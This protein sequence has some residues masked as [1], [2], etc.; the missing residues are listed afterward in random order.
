MSGFEVRN[1]AGSVTVNSD[2]KSPLLTNYIASPPFDTTG[3]WDANIPDMGRLKDLAYLKDSIL[4]NGGAYNRNYHKPGQIMWV[5]LNVGGWGLP[6]CDYYIPGS[7]N[8]AFTRMDATVESG[9][10]DVFNSSGQLIWSA[11]SAA[12]VPRIIGF[13]TVPP[14]FD[15]LNNT[16]TVS[17]PGRPFFPTDMF[18]GL[19]S[20]DGEGVGG[21][22]SL[23]LKQNV[24]SISLRYDIY[25]NPPYTENPLY[26][27]G[28]KIP[29]AIFPTL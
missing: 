24:D 25:N 12:T 1:I 5:R 27:R 21:R 6:G 4:Y 17:V 10:L 3:D 11:K 7:V 16:L 28:F 8:I 29:Y 22:A 13:I 18:P 23:A 15:L 2:Y 14:N 26:Y 20:L 9:Y 19:L